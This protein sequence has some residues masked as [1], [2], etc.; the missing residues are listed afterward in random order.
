MT[1]CNKQAILLLFLYFSTLLQVTPASAPSTQSTVA[2]I[3]PPPY[4][5]DGHDDSKNPTWYI[6]TK[7]L[8]QWTPISSSYDITLY[9]LGGSING[10]NVFGTVPTI[11]LYHKYPSFLVKS[12]AN[13]QGI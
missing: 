11:M 13:G 4:G 9:Q 10:E 1:L 2:F 6:G 5:D 7:E 12:P 3:N 8:I